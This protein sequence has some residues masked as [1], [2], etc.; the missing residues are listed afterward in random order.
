MN[1]PVCGKP[2]RHGGLAL[3]GS[4]PNYW[5]S[6]MWYCAS[7]YACDFSGIP[8]FPDDTQQEHEE[9]VAKIRATMP[10]WRREARERALLG[11]KA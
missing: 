5:R 6:E 2:A 8:I 9:I 4:A 1:C 11:G 10:R 3:R 7:G